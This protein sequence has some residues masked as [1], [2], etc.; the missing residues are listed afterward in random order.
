LKSE[1]GT[2]DDDDDDDEEWNE[3]AERPRNKAAAAA[4]KRSGA[5]S[6]SSA[7]RDS[8]G[9][10]SL[11]S[12]VSAAT[13][14]TATTA[15]SDS[16]GLPR[17]LL[18][19]VDGFKVEELKD[20]L[21]LIGL[22]LAGRKD[23][24]KLR[25][26]DGLRERQDKM[27]EGGVLLPDALPGRKLA[28]SKQP[29]PQ[30]PAQEPVRE[31]HVEAIDRVGE[32]KLDSTPS[33]ARLAA[34]GNPA[35]TSKSKPRRA[36]LVACGGINGFCVDECPIDEP[37]GGKQLPEEHDETT[38]A[39]SPTL[40]SVAR[41]SAAAPAPAPGPRAAT[42]KELAST[43]EAPAPAPKLSAAS[44]E[45]NI[46]SKALLPALQHAAPGRPAVT[47][48]DLAHKPSAQVRAPPL[49]ADPRALLAGAKVATAALEPAASA[50]R[51]PAGLAVSAR[52]AAM[53]LDKEN[54]AVMKRKLDEFRANLDAMAR[55]QE[56]H[57]LGVLSDSVRPA[58]SLGLTARPN[59]SATAS[60]GPRPPL[61]R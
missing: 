52:P 41:P 2:S 23:A 47:R 11:A 34:L 8:T 38:S 59:G 28:G 20:A 1:P 40:D 37:C 17:D 56:P 18:A 45:R 29:Q 3:R 35:A 25:L 39:L 6:F 43:G 49:V 32:T 54:L 16:G 33:G 58:P 26:L 10:A 48:P 31:A 19:R 21:A 55:E 13:V 27:V 15:E 57:H 30:E 12:G 60:S 7:N 44:S 46:G 53:P 5:S 24:L 61:G 9:A 36:S 51:A 4:A 22:P 50:P 14:A 42:E